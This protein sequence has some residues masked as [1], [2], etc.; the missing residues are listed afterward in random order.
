MKQELRGGC[1][2]AGYRVELHD[3]NFALMD[4]P[5]GEKAIFFL[6]DPITR[7]VSGFHSRKRQGMPRFFFP[8]RP[9]E[10]AAFAR[11]SSPDELAASLS[12]DNSER[13]LAAVE[14]M[15]RIRHVKDS[16]SRWLGTRDYF[17]AR[18][19][20]IFFVGFQEQLSEDFQRL[21]SKLGFPDEI[22][23]P[24]DDIAAH[25]NPSGIDLEVGETAA[26]NLRNWYARDY[27]LVAL[28]RDKAPT[29]NAA[30]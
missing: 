21:Q 2:G 8:W 7:F 11:F 1:D 14:A 20:D 6:R 16:Y 26:T 29:I 30:P 17:L 5:P 4:V 18:L 28:C 3:H 9:A 15:R 19:P 10:K 12:S 24:S 27:E 22:A 13:R 25:R 23:L